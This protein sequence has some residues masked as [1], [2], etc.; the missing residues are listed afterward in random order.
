MFRRFFPQKR[1]YLDYAASTP[2]SR[3]VQNSMCPYWSVSFANPNSIHH[4]G[5][6]AA[7][8]VS[9]CAQSIKQATN[10]TKKS[11]VV[12]TSGG[13]ESNQL[14]VMHAINSWKS[15]HGDVPFAVVTS[16]LEHTSVLKYLQSIQD[17]LMT[18]CY[19]DIDHEGQISY[20]HLSQLLSEKPHIALVTIQLQSS[21]IGVTQNIKKISKLVNSTKALFPKIHV[22]ASQGLLYKKIDMQSWGA[23][24]VTLCAQKIYGPKGSGALLCTEGVD[25]KKQGTPAV[26]LIV[27]TT[28]A[29][30]DAQVNTQANVAKI[31][32]VRAMLL[33]EMKKRDIQFTC[34]GNAVEDSLIVNIS[35]TKSEK[36][37]EQLII[38]C[39]QVGLELSSKSACIGSQKSDSRLL[40]SM[41]VNAINSIRISL[42]H[43]YTI[44][45]IKE[46]TKRLK[47]VIAG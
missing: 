15:I 33:A 9:G 28:Q 8:V 6:E 5:R 11:K 22:D 34:N 16:H 7:Q 31:T 17:P 32:K 20:E 43:D 37:S 26:P 36:D 29:L 42:S 23:D 18:I 12:W 27:G 41:G 1:Y 39:D 47:Q 44:R 21:E 24:T 4:A 25:I 46:I 19:V 3:S 45:D 14:A 2:V 13:T 35:F 10:M 40:E 38:A 30:I